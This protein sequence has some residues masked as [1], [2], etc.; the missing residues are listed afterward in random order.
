MGGGVGG[1]EPAAAAVVVVFVC[2]ACVDGWMEEQ[3][4][5]WPWG[6]LYVV[7]WDLSSTT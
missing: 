4:L 6:D 3:K 2:R 7:D 1:V 5:S